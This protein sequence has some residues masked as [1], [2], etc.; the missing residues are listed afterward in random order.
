LKIWREPDL[1]GEFAVGERGV[2]VFP[3]IGPFNVAHLSID[4]LTRTLTALYSVSLRSPA[5]EVT[6][7]RRIN[8]A[9][10]VR[11][12][13]FFYA[14]PTVTVLGALALAGGV[15]IDGDQKHIALVRAGRTSSISV[16]A[17]GSLADSPIQSG[18][19]IRVP[20]R[21]WMARNTALIASGVT[22]VALVIAAV[23]RP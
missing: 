11:N 19:D 20:E 4:S 13:G 8:V 14:D 22:G 21:S 7:L 17:E 6:A 9:G 5:V 15:T 23:L 12:S 10:A 16:G 3:K 1:S 18:D 2:V